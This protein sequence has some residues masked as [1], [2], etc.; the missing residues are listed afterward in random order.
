MQIKYNVLVPDNDANI[1]FTGSDGEVCHVPMV[2]SLKYLGSV[3]DHNGK[4]NMDVD[5]RISLAGKSWHMVKG[6]LLSRGINDSIRGLLYVSL[7]VSILL[8][9]SENWIMNDGI[10]RKL[11]KFHHSCVR[12]MCGLTFWH[13]RH[14]RIR[15]DTLLKRLDI[16]PIEFYYSRRLLQ[17][18]GHVARMPF[19]RLPRMCLTGWSPHK[20]CRGNSRTWGTSLNRQLKAQGLPTNCLEWVHLAQDRVTWRTLISAVVTP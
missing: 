7:L 2:K 5:N 10:M 12:K 20:R 8:Y 11:R 14:Q 1:V 6:A 16:K 19:S 13:T 3:I 18:A 17:W 4:S 15:N 9:G